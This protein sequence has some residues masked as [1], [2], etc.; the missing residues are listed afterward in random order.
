MTETVSVLSSLWAAK[1]P[2]LLF[3]AVI[4]GFFKYR[5]TVTKEFNEHDKRIIKVETK[6]ESTYDPFFDKMFE[7]AV[8][9]VINQD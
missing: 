2:I 5:A 1:E 4:A 6:C 3:I 7:D 9:R 8:N